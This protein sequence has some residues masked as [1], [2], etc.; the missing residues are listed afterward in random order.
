MIDKI[1][2]KVLSSDAAS[3]GSVA[4]AGAPTLTVG[5]AR[6]ADGRLRRHPRAQERGV[7]RTEGCDR[8]AYTCA[9]VHTAA[10]SRLLI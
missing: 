8:S 9:S 5:T 7:L 1:T 2:A 6:S 10:S 4:L 3:T